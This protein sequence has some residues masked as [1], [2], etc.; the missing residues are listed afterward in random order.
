MEIL[1]S[2]PSPVVKVSV[3]ARST[4]IYLFTNYHGDV[5]AAFTVKH[6]AAFWYLRQDEDLKKEMKV[7]IVHDG[8]GS[9]SEISLQRLFK[10]TGYTY[11]EDD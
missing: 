11:D 10:G 3:M 1:G 9:S 4:N 7:F 2:I 6:E 8:G 5:I